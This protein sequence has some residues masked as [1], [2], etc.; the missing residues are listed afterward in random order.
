[1]LYADRVPD[2]SSVDA[3]LA[4]AARA[5]SL[6][7]AGIWSA[8]AARDPFLPLAVAAGP[9][10]RL[11][12]GTGIA[13]AYARA[14]Y[15]TAIASWDLQRLTGGR[16]RLGLATQVRAH[17]ERRFGMSWPGGVGALREYVQTMRAV[18]R[19]FQTGERP[20]FEGRHYRFTLMNPEFQPEP[21]PEDHSHIPVWLAAVGPASA[22][23]AGEVADGLHVHAFHTPGYLRDVVFRAVH[24]GR[25]QA[26]AA[27][28]IEATCPVF[29]GTAHDDAQ[30][31]ELREEFRTALAFYASTRGYLPVLEYEGLGALQAPLAELARERRWD[32]M[33]ALIDDEVLDRFVVIDEPVRLARRLLERYD[34]LLTELALYRGGDRFA[35]DEDMALLVEE[36]G[37]HHAPALV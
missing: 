25:E 29:A 1:M 21:L 13:V 4:R 37:R 23:L 26:G 5:E 10:V 18:W 31:R 35:S 15:A 33:P 7:M 8:E 20:D 19:T 9:T 32:D 28:G 17:I 16:F 27:P 30:A 12:L 34:G 2:T 36:L 3:I 24:E 14:P 22:R 11:Q 6:G